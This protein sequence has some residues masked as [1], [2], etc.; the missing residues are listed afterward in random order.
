MTD[1]Y[2]IEI[3]QENGWAV[4]IDNDNGGLYLVLLKDDC[5]NLL[6]RGWVSAPFTENFR[7]KILEPL[8]GDAQLCMTAYNTLVD[9]EK[10]DGECVLTSGE[11]VD[12]I[13][14]A[15]VD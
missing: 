10:E 7:H 2:A 6:Y 11:R 15:L 4:G 8:A 13:F 1:E 14:S 12:A 5:K 3:A 9:F